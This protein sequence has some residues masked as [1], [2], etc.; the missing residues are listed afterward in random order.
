MMLA[1]FFWLTLV[2]DFFQ[3]TSTTTIF[4]VNFGQCY[5]LLASVTLAGIAKKIALIDIARKIALADVGQKTPTNIDRKM[6][7]PKKHDWSKSAKKHDWSMLAK[8]NIIG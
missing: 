3:S 4:L 5:F 1:R 7:W 2:N 6:S 8:K